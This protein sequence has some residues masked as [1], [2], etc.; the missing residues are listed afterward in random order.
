MERR[1]LG[2]TGHHSSV[3]VL[4]CAA[5]AKASPEQTEKSFELALHRG[6]N[7]LDVA[8]S[9]GD[10]EANLGPL[11][12]HHRDHLF[13]A[14]KTHR[15]NPDGVRAQLEQTLRTLQVEQLDLY[16]LHGVTDLDDLDARAPAV[17]VLLEAKAQGLTRHLG[18]T[19]HDLGTAKAQLEALRRWDLDTVMFPLSPRLW[20]EADYRADVQALL[21]HC[22]IHD[23]GV[24]VIKAVSWRPWGDRPPSLHTWYEPHT[25][26]ERI[27]RGVD[28][29]L[30][31]PG[32]HCF[33]TPGDRSLL[34]PVLAAA[35]ATGFVSTSRRQ[36][37]VQE[38][39]DEPLIFPMAEHAPG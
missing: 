37:I 25:D 12:P 3:A 36:T 8:P 22:R 34:E 11:L 10:A 21:S 27:A 17:E 35:E 15:R 7:H 1:R 19:G 18:I 9:Y 26:P 14:A 39:A 24:Q 6:V 33:A 30:S 29:V 13:V 28:F 23:V 20:S 5:F 16:Q 2:R 38:A 4:G 31:T 32:V